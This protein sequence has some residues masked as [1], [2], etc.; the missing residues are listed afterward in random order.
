MA[1]A[2]KTPFSPQESI[3]APKAL[4]PLMQA[5][6]AD[7]EEQARALILEAS[8]ILH[9]ESCLSKE[10]IAC[11]ASLIRDMKPQDDLELLYAAQVTMCHLLGMRRLSESYKDDK[12]LGLKL[13]KFGNEAMQR[14]TMK[15]GGAENVAISYS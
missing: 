5:F 10:E 3:S 1:K 14:L 15:T 8:K 9:G 7:T 2:Q 6:H 13:L 12:K 4:V 11:A